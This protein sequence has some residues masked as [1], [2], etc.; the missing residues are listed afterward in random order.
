M[1]AVIAHRDGT[2]HVVELDQP[3][4]GPGTVAIR[5]SHSGIM[6]PHELHL[7]PRVPSRLKKGQDGLPVGSM[8]SGIVDEVGERVEGLKAGLRVAAFGYPYVYHASHLSVPAN[9]VMELPKKVN[10]EEGA[11][12]GQGA[13]VVHLV[14]KAKVTLGEVLLVFGAGMTGILAA[15]IARAAGAIPVLVDGAEQK[16]TKARNVGVT[17]TFVSDD[18]AL[19]REIDSMTDGEGADAAIVTADA[20][21]KAGE[22]AGLFLREGGRVI[23]GADAGGGIPPE[24]IAEKELSVGAVTG[25][26]PGFGD[27]AWELSGQ[28]Y[29]SSLVRWTLRGNLGVFLGLLAERRVQISPLISERMPMDRAASCYERIVRSNGGVIGALLTV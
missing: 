5:V 12:A 14:R 23:V 7:L 22:M 20:D 27:R 15:Q 10:H 6:L 11:F 18:K 29:P 9:L 17:S 19:V 13:A 24:L 16:L 25:V 3:P 28:G 1:K 8:C 21:D 4:V 2:P 26:G